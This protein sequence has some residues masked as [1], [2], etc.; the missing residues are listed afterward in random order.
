MI[1]FRSAA[2]TRD[3]SECRVTSTTTI[4]QPLIEWSP[5]Y[6]GTGWQVNADP[7][8]VVT[9]YT[10]ATCAETWQIETQ[11]ADPPSRDESMQ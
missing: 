1:A 2:C 6:D 10:C 11:A 7:N 8:T 3:A 4:K 5:I 9:V